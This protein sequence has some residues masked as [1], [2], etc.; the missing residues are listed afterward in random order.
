MTLRTQN[1]GRTARHSFLLNSTT[2]ALEPGID[3]N[4]FL[5]SF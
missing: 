5:K 3:L 2:Q 1:T 4:A